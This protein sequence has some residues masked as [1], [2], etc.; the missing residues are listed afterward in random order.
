MATEEG[1]KGH[2]L[3]VVTSPKY[4]QYLPSSQGNCSP[5]P[6]TYEPLALGKASCGDQQ[7]ALEDLACFLLLPTVQGRDV[8]F[9]WE[10][11]E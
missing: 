2:Q 5:G 6:P 1:K 11:G 4:P 10:L 8:P 3:T 9:L 7:S